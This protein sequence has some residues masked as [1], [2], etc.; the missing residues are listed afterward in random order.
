M[1]DIIGIDWNEAWKKRLAQRTLISRSAKSW[2]K[3]APSFAERSSRS[4]Y[5]PAFLKIVK[6]ER[7]WTVFDMGC[8]SGTLAIPLAKKVREV[9]AA[10][11]SETMLEMLS[12]E[13]HQKG[14]ENIR[15]INMKWEDDWDENN[16]GLHDIAVASRSLVVTDLRE[17]ITK[18]D[19][20]ASKAVYISTIVGDGPCDRKVFEAV[21]RDL[22]MGPDYIYSYNL[23]YQMG[24]KARTDFIVEKERKDYI[25]HDEAFESLSWM[26]G[27]LTGREEGLLKNYVQEHLVR[28]NG[29]WMLD[30]E[31]T[32]T[33]AV[34]SWEK[35]QE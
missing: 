23:L 35:S 12:K 2:D 1:K 10:D 28:E 34:L 20:R 4:G 18:L 8:G 26:V 15:I 11:F 13:A 24:I 33:W 30:Y 21:G 17:A 29:S 32:I 9:I 6:T 19:K 14:L 27:D 31:R 25:D 3:R 16:I 5:G 7:D 22:D